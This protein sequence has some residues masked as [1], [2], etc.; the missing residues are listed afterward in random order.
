M[1]FSSDNCRSTYASNLAKRS[2]SSIRSWVSSRLRTSSRKSGS[3]RS[4]RNRSAVVAMVVTASTSPYAN[5]GLSRMVS[6]RLGPV[7]TICT[8]QPTSVS[9]RRT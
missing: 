9:M 5:T 3:S 7:E 6:V 1:A 8:G 4:R 2:G